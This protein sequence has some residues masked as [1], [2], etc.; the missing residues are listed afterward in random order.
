LPSYSE[1]F[2]SVILE[3]LAAGLPVITTTGTPW[4]ELEKKG[5]GWWRDIDKEPLSTILWQAMMM[6]DQRRY[7]MGN[8]GHVWALAEFA[9]PAI[10]RKTAAVYDW[11]LTGCRRG[12]APECVDYPSD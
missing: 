2:G 1:N 11:I 4:A 12:E 7:E 5:C 3:A 10:A 6:D 9:W 8:R